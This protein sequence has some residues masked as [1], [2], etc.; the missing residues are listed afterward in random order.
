MEETFQENFHEQVLPAIL[1]MLEDS[2]PRVQ[3]HA[4]AALTNFLEAAP[5]EVSSNY[6]EPV[7]PKLFQLIETSISVIKENAVTAIASIAETSEE[8]FVPYFDN[9]LKFLFQMLNALS[10]PVYRQFR[11]QCIECITI[12]AAAVGYEAFKQSAGDIISLLLSIQNQ[13]VA[14]SKD[15]QKTYLL[16]AW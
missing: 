6:I 4:C 3:A 5:K 2:V 10:E 11:G 14:P 15:P 16:S 13:Q 1:Q 12:M 8:K 9:T 7:L